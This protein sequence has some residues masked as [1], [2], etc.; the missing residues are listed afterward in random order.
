[1]GEQAENVTSADSAGRWLARDRDA[2]RDSADRAVLTGL[3]AD[4]R[5]RVLNAARLRPGHDVLDLGA[6]TGLLTHAAARV[7]APAGSVIAVD[8]SAAALAQIRTNEAGIRPVVGDACHLPIADATFDRV[9]ARS[10]LIYLPDLRAALR[11]VAR[12]LRP[13]G[14]LSA[15]EPVNA[16]RRHDANLDGVTPDEIEAIDR[17]RSLSSPSAGPMMAF[18]VAPFVDAALHAGFSTPTVG[19]TTLTERLSTRA[20]VDAHLNRRPHPGAASPVDLIT[21]HLGADTTVRYVTA[22][23]RALDKAVDRG[24]IT[25]TTPVVYLTAYLGTR[26]YGHG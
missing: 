22:W 19:E 25:F 26:R 9:V 4:I 16:R 24:G 1:M 2:G 18:D 7:V 5:D 15:F 3:L 6:G 21:R 10:V 17:L 8:R 23:Y 14:L 12:V 11:E 20:H 13:E